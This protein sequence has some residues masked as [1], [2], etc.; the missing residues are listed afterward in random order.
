LLT[1]ETKGSTKPFKIIILLNKL[2]DKLKE[3]LDSKNKMTQL[4]LNVFGIFNFFFVFL[5]TEK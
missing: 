1:F 4:G 2:N 5:K 3:K